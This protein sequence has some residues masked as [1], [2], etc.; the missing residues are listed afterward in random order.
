MKAILT[1]AVIILLVNILLLDFDNIL[2]V[3]NN[4]TEYVNIGISIFTTLIL[5]FTYKERSKK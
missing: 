1:L 3:K 4:I 2:S 5:Y